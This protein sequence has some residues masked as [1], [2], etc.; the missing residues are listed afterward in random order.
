LQARRPLFADVAARAAVV[1]VGLQVDARVVA[2]REARAARAR[3]GAAVADGRAAAARR[4]ARAAVLRVRPRVD[5]R[6]VARRLRARAATRPVRA[7]LR[8]ATDFAARAAVQVARREIDAR[9]VAVREPWV[10]GARADAEAAHLSAGAR[11][12]ACPAVLRIGVDVDARGPA[13]DQIRRARAAVGDVDRRGA[14]ARRA[15][16]HGEPKRARERE[17]RLSRLVDHRQ[18]R[19]QQARC[20]AQIGDFVEDRGSRLVTRLIALVTALRTRGVTST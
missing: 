2:V 7:R 3:A 15:D 9:S 4:A 17:Q 16:R 20:Q 11:V 8:R 5:A 1:V 6:A 13:R 19:A 10:A 18:A 14:A 12:T